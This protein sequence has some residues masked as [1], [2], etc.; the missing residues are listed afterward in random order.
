M[1]ITVML[2]SYNSLN[3]TIYVWG[4]TNT[5]QYSIFQFTTI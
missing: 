2:L 1:Y 3:C 4:A 5:M